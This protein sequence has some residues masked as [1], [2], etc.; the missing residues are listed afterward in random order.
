MF[1]TR[2]FTFGKGKYKYASGEHYCNKHLSNLG[3]ILNRI[4]QDKLGIFLKLNTGHSQFLQIEKYIWNLVIHINGIFHSSFL[5]KDYSGTFSAMIYQPTTWFSLG[6]VDHKLQPGTDL[7][8]TLP[9]SIN[10]DSV[11]RRIFI[12]F[13]VFKY[14]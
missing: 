7:G 10:L 5:C 1:R 14:L 11:H 6:L 12:K 8:T 3:D 9:F 2:F 4:Y 13:T